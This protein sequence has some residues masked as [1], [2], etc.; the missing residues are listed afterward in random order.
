M[1]D[2]ELTNNTS[3]AVHQ[4]RFFLSAGDANAE[5]RLS[6][7]VLATKIIDIATEHANMLGIGNPDMASLKAG[8]IL[9]RLTI[10]MEAYPKVNTEYVL[11]TWIEDFNRHFSTRCFSIESPEGHK[12]GFARSIWLVMDA[13][14]HTNYGTSHLKLPEG[15]ILGEG[16]PMARQE[17]HVAIVPV[18]QEETET[19]KFLTATHPP[20]PYTFKYCDLDFY[21]HVNT[22]RY[23][24]M[25]LNQ[26]SLKEHD[27]SM[28]TRMELSFLHEASYGMKTILLRS[29]DRGNP[30]NSSFQLSDETEGQPLLFARINRK[31]ID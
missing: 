5:G 28:I 20:Y 26:F 3:I 16:V 7:T 19:K 13:V 24:A 27:E 29:D 14:N 6:L 2:M 23:I 10:G 25:L 9:S 15:S 31:L 8:W 22:V 18:G 11:K 17:K 12:Y 1:K 30:L 21:R 4:G